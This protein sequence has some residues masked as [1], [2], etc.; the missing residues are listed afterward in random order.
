MHEFMKPHMT[1]DQTSEFDELEIKICGQLTFFFCIKIIVQ[2][3]ANYVA[4]T[5]E[6]GDA[7]M[8]GSI[9]TGGLVSLK[10][11]LWMSR[12]LLYPFK[13]PYLDTQEVFLF[14]TLVMRRQ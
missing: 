8:N 2:S 3:Y 5:K 7:L 11:T 10:I 9:G 6:H 4:E 13:L 1:H 14:C 12:R